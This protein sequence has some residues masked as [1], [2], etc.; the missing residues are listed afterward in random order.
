MTNSMED[1]WRVSEDSMSLE[2]ALDRLIGDVP[3]QRAVAAE[4]FEWLKGTIP[5]RCG[6]RLGKNRL[7]FLIGNYRPAAIKRVGNRLRV[8]M[9][10]TEKLPEEFSLASSVWNTLPGTKEGFYRVDRLP[11]PLSRTDIENFVRAC[12]LMKDMAPKTRRHT[13]NVEVEWPERQ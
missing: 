13:C 2:T 6:V 10:F 11:L 5:F 12:Y 1:L 7:T 3:S 4:M 8:D 9:G